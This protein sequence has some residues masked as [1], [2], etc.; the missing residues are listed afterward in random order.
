M[1]SEPDLGPPLRETGTRLTVDLGSIAAN[2]R[3]LAERAAPAACAA[4]VKADG[5]GLGIEP[6]SRA[7]AAAGATAFFVAHLAEARQVRAVAPEATIYVLNG[8]VPGTAEAYAAIGARPVLGSRPEI[9]EWSR[10]AG[11]R[12]DA[13][14][15][16][17]VDTGMNRLG[18]AMT[19]AAEV[20]D[21][22]TEGRLG[23]SPALAM[24]HFACADEPDHP[25]N[26]RQR[27]L[28]ADVRRLF[29]GVPASLANSAA[30]LSGG[31]AGLCD[32]G[33][34]GIALYGGNAIPARANPMAAVVCFEARIIQLREVPAGATVGYGATETA[35]TPLR[36]AVASVGYADGLIRAAGSSDARLGAPADVAGRRCPLVGRISMDLVALDV[37]LVPPDEVRPGDWATLIGNA[38]TIDEVAE[39]AGTIG[40]EILTGLGRRAHRIYV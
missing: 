39:A 32:L 5:Y 16:I 19:E 21:R 4:V 7:L 23:F 15:A 24:S 30:I 3:L 34:P 26:A 35:K 36:L 13:P 9:E 11:G 14:A 25:L 22:L 2:W 8:L 40:Y 38:I 17:Q 28:F 12:G 31:A 20:A 1:A 10:F 37:T 29:P 27:D 18:L 6:V 33:R